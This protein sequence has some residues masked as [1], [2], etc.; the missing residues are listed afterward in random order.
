M[1]G[2]R[3]W[4]WT[5][6]GIAFL[7]G[8]TW[9]FTIPPS[10][11]PDEQAH[12]VKAA[13]VARGDLSTE[14]EWRPGWF[15]LM[16]STPVDVVT[17]YNY[18][19]L[20]D[21]LSC[22]S[23]VERQPSNCAPPLAER[24]G[25]PVTTDTYVGVYQ[26]TYYAVVGW[27]T[28]FLAPAKGVYAARMAGVAIGA[29]LVASALASARSLGRST[30]TGAVLALPPAVA[31]LA[32]TVNP[33]GPE[34]LAASAVWT[35]GLLALGQPD[36]D[37]RVIV[38]LGAA[39]IVLMS[40]RPTGVVLA[41]LIAGALAVVAADREALRSLWRRRSA[42]WAATFVI[43]AFA[44]NAIHV[45]ANDALSTVIKK[46]NTDTTSE[47]LRSA[48]DATPRLLT[49]QVGLLSWEGFVTLDLPRPLVQL[50]LVAVAALV[51]WAL[52]AGTARQ[53]LAVV[54]LVIG[55][56]AM[57]LAAALL[58]PEVGWQGRYG[59]PIG[60]GIPIVA[61][62]VVDRRAHRSAGARRTPARRMIPA[63][64]LVA[65]T[66]LSGL[67]LLAGQA[68]VMSRNLHGQ[69]ST[70]F[71]ARDERLWNG[72]LTPD[73]LFVGAL[74]A[75][76]AIIGAGVVSLRGVRGASWSGR[77]RSSHSSTRPATLPSVT[78]DGSAPNTETAE[79]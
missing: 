62:W 69:P 55:W 22:W 60:L 76:T 36:V 57:P 45:V 46:E 75:T 47:I 50:W 56:A 40:A 51:V 18:G 43:V 49:S 15:G 19:A 78:T 32:S 23:G 63:A 66:V 16:P 4:W 5:V 12:L 48:A 41:A 37:K 1:E 17:G 27:P 52:A 70:L 11:G 21:Q 7:V 39:A 29:A 25:R 42:R 6:F 28:R 8:A 68:K 20:Y 71:A 79:A 74:V 10:G 67:A 35:T 44:V 13:G 34:I 64:A 14:V 9:A 30:L 38:R 3:P 54:A 59:L 72:P 73:L 24:T 33:Q 31:F 2:E 77:P 58:N 53:K 26:P 65:A 61:G